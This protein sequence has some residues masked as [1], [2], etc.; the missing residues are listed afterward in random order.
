MK[1]KVVSE[2]LPLW[3]VVGTDSIISRKVCSELLQNMGIDMLTIFDAEAELFV[4]GP[5]AKNLSLNRSVDLENLLSPSF[6]SRKL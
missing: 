6:T 1:R 4:I 5:Q 2:V 3:S